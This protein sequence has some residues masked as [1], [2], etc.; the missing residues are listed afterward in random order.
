M[1]CIGP[2]TIYS[3][4]DI[5]SGSTPLNQFCGVRDREGVLE[6]LGLSGRQILGVAAVAIAV[7]LLVVPLFSR[8]GGQ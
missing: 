4:V 3:G 1:F 6:M 2:N 8:N 5:R 7:N